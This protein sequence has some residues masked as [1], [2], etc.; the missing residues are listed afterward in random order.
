MNK[1]IAALLLL[2]FAGV[3]GARCED[4]KKQPSPKKAEVAVIKT[5]VGEMVIEF[6]PD[7]ARH[8]KRKREEKLARQ[9][10]AQSKP[11][12]TSPDDTKK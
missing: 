9:A 8:M 5:T 4:E 12:T 11:P 10:A 6:W 2:A 7:L 3:T 1:C